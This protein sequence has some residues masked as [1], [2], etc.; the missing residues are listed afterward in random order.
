MLDSSLRFQGA[1]WVYRLIIDSYLSFTAEI[2]KSAEKTLCD[3]KL[4]DA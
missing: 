1:S 2:A 4:W 3:K